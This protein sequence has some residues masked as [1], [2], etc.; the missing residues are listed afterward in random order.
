MQHNPL[1][2]YWLDKALE[3][4]LRINPEIRYEALSEW[5]QDLKR[6][7]P[8]WIT[9]RALPIMETHPDRVWKF[10]AISGW[11]CVLGILLFKR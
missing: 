9:P 3:K 8:D 1:V 10:L 6:P 2:P 7:N 4:A 11:L 5:L